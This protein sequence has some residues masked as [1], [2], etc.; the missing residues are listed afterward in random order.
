MKAQEIFD[1]LQPFVTRW[2][3]EFRFPRLSMVLDDDAITISPEERWNYISGT[4]ITDL[5]MLASVYGWSFGIHTTK[6][7]SLYILL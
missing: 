1:I 6:E 4:F 2:N 3:E 7:G 5:A